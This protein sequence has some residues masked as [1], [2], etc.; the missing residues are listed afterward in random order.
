MARS[1]MLIGWF[2]VIGAGIGL[3]L[4]AVNSQA[5]LTLANARVRQAEEL[6]HEVEKDLG[7]RIDIVDPDTGVMLL[8]AVNEI[9]RLREGRQE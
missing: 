3:I 8:A 9:R 5:K 2:T 7:M 1:L 4:W 6:L